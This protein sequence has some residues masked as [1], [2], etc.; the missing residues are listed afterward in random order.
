VTGDLPTV[1]RGLLTEPGRPRLT[2]YGP[3]GERVEL[4]GHVLDNWVTKTTNLLVEELDLGPG[5]SVLLDLPAH[6][7]TVVWA[8]AVWRTGACVLLGP[9]G[10]HRPDVVVTADPQS[11]RDPG[12]EVVV[13]ALPALARGVGA[14]LPAGA[15]DAA[16]AVMTYGDRLGAVP[17]TDPARAALRV[18]DG[19]PVRHGDLLAWAA[20]AWG[21]EPGAA[22]AP[23]A[24]VLVEPADE[25][26]GPVLRAVL[27][28]YAR[29]G[30]VVLC[31]PSLSTELA[32]D[33]TR[34]ERL[35]S[36]ERV[37]G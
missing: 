17:P 8:L 7:R 14:D 33:P 19:D 5:R 35:A 34:R 37:T 27:A 26:A 20:A 24:R 28:V 11:P 6:W 22:P 23:G 13:V 25:A 4:S 1:L 2:W 3:D 18:D 30:S 16:A 32:G 29:G 9:A 36:A 21:T 10:R 12:A 15:I 31:A